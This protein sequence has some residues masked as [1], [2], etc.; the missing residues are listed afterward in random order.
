M[1]SRAEVTRLLQDW[2]AGDREALDRLVPLIY[3]ELRRLARLRLRGQRPDHTLGT[4]A[5]VHEAFLRLVD[6]ERV[7]F[8]NRAH[9]LGTASKA[10]RSVLVDHARRRS[11]QKRGGGAHPVPLDNA[12]DL[13]AEDATRFLELEDALRGLEEAHARQGRVLEQHYIGGLSLDEIAE[14]AGISQ[15]TV[16]RDLRF[17]RAWLAEELGPGPGSGSDT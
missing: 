15:A 9:F 7:D 10:M 14:A 6:A 3:E 5:L 4:T 16:K 17:A 11:A 12:L 8:R 1:D 2:T 13:A